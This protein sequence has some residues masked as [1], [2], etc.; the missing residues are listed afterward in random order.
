MYD[1]DADTVNPLQE[2][3]L[4]AAR[5]AVVGARAESGTDATIVDGVLRRLDA[6]GTD[7]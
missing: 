2:E 1:Q 5:D 7:G 3:L 4:E 6:R